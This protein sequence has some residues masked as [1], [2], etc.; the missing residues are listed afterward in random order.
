MARATSRCS[1]R[2]MRPGKPRAFAVAVLGAVM[3]LGALPAAETLAQ[4]APGHQLTL[5]L[6]PAGQGRIEVSQEGSTFA[7]CGFLAIL[8][9]ENPCE[10]TVSSGAPVTLTAVAEPAATIPDHLQSKVPDFPA[11]QTAFAHWSRF[12]CDGTASCTFVPD[13]DLDWITAV[14]TPLQLQ[15]GVNGTGDVG[16]QQPD[17]SID[18]LPCE[19]DV[20]FGDSTCHALFPADTDV[21]LVA[22]KPHRWAGCEPEGGNPES[23]KCTVTMTNIR[24]FAGVTF[25]PDS[26]PPGLPFQI[27]AR[28]RVTRG[29]SGQGSV[30][31]SGITCGTACMVDL[32]YQAR[33]SL[34]ADPS[35]GSTF[36][37][38][39]GVCATSP[40]CLFSAGSATVIQARFEASP[41]AT[42]LAPPP[43][44]TTSPSTPTPTPTPTPAPTPAPSPTTRAFAPQLA[45]VS[46][47]G[48]GAGRVIALVVIADRPA[49][50]RVRLLKRGRRVAA[51]TFALASRRNSIRLRVPRSARAGA[52]RLSLRIVAGSNT[53]TVTRP[54]RIP[55]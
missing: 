45:R 30:T 10:V 5:R 49:R 33:V 20:D 22:A 11:P 8:E 53:R 6:W 14:F 47:L 25:D 41:P 26:D 2:S 34:K 29:G 51:R 18:A 38:W 15:V 50:L 35:P 40:T 48:R 52:Y 32:D 27:T 3:L 36:V 54:L 37:R 46:T 55:R 19:E 43:A 21:V 28:I 23:A 44:A 1:A 39:V 4:P 13:A 24:T 42:P 17:G 9:N 7:P 31:G 12:G 16:V